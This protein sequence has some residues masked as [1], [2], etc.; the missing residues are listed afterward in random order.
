MGGPRPDHIT[1]PDYDPKKLDVPEGRILG[2]RQLQFLNDWGQD[3]QG[4]HM[5]AVLSQTIFA[6]AA[7]RHG[8]Y[9]NRLVA[10]LDSN[11]WPQS[12]RDRAVRAMLKAFV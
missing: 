5:K 8:G 6:D 12:A 9:D 1:D 3:W 2:K 7:H 10:D 4:A 11:G